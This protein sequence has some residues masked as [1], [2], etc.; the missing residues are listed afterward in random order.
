METY[1][2]N[3]LCWVFFYVNNNTQIDNNN[4]QMM[5]CILYYTSLVNA[6]NIRTWA[7]KNLISYYKTNGKKKFN[8]HVNINH[9]IIAKELKQ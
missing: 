6:S 9:A 4:P 7:L 5:H 1:G 2:K 8:K 3:S